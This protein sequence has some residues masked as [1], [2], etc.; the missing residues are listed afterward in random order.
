MLKFR[1]LVAALCDIK[2]RIA[3]KRRL[4]A[5]KRIVSGFLFAAI[6]YKDTQDSLKAIL[7]STASRRRV[8]IFAM[9]DIMIEYFQARLH[10]LSVGRG[11]ANALAF[12]SSGTIVLALKVVGASKRVNKV[13]STLMFDPSD[14]EIKPTVS[15]LLSAVVSR[16]PNAPT[17]PFNHAPILV[18]NFVEHQS[19]KNGVW[20]T[21][22]ITG[23]YVNVA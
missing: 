8:W 15:M 23:D 7:T 3:R 10:R 5:V 21:R 2:R 20:T 16:A 17:T 13:I 9:F 11:V 1:C 22:G 4:V 12:V 6:V 14:L 19:V 18:E